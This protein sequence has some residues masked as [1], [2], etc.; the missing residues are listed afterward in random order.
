MQ[1]K[2]YKYNNIISL[3][4]IVSFINLFKK[5]IYDDV[6]FIEIQIKLVHSNGSEIVNLTGNDIFKVNS[7]SKMKIFMR[8]I[9][10]NV[11]LLQPHYKN[12]VFSEIQ[13]HYKEITYID[14]IRSSQDNNKLLLQKFIKTVETKNH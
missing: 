12:D 6:K 3:E 10:K 11:K 8:I 7:H 5:D 14:F 4:N 1:I 9:N 2:T 13:F